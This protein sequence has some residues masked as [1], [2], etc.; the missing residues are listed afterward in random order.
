MTFQRAVVWW[1]LSNAPSEFKSYE[2]LSVEKKKP[3]K[4]ETAINQSEWRELN[5]NRLI[6]IET[7]AVITK[8]KNNN[9]Y[10]CLTDI[11]RVN[12]SLTNPLTNQKT[13]SSPSVLFLLFHLNSI[14]CRH[15]RVAASLQQQTTH[16]TAQFVKS[17]LAISFNGVN[18][19]LIPS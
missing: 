2:E 10:P 15:C 7:V 16:A 13:S 11:S 4:S 1:W 3:V 18:S 17:T 5:R 8:E 9:K 12:L 6:L 14:N 19:N